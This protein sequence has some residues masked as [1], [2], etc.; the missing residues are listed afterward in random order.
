MD[1]V[2]NTAPV[3]NS[4]HNGLFNNGLFNRVCVDEE[5]ARRGGRDRGGPVF[6]RWQA[7]P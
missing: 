5:P 3:R 2:L 4:M 1:V 7:I 6:D